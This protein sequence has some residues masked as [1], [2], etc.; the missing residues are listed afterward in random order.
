MNRICC[1]LLIV[2]IGAVA[3]CHTDQKDLSVV[4]DLGV[5]FVDRSDPN[6]LRLAGTFVLE[7]STNGDIH[8]AV[9]QISCGCAAVEFPQVV[10][11]GSFEVTMIVNVPGVRERRFEEASLVFQDTN[12]AEISTTSI[13]FV[14]NVFPRLC[15][16]LPDRWAVIDLSE[17]NPYSNVEF[18]VSAYVGKEDEDEDLVLSVPE[19]IAD[20]VSF[21]ASESKRLGDILRVQRK[22]SLQL[23]ELK[24]TEF[25]QADKLTAHFGNSA[26]IVPFKVVGKESVDI[27]PDEIFLSKTRQ[28]AKI[29]LRSLTDESTQDIEL[30]SN[31]PAVKVRTSSDDKDT[32]E[33]YLTEDCGPSKKMDF[34]ISFHKDGDS[35]PLATIPG[36]VLWIK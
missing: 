12:G 31:H 25:S 4:V 1:S 32:W 29:V 11:P 2:W 13:E 9:G 21:G 33:V 18:L 17:E 26:L 34:T 30:V 6:S 36:R 15:T 3:G 27:S 10:P 16:N 20:A 35:E 19:S 24:R 23:T 5:K 7:N 8:L 22:V 28:C 14:C